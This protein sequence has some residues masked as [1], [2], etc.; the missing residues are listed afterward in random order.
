MPTPSTFVRAKVKVHAKEQ[1]LGYGD[2]PQVTIKA[3]PVT[4]S[5]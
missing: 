5:P 1:T 3:R 4:S 2:E